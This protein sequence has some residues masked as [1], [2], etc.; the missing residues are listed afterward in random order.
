MI[1][2]EPMSE[3]LLGACYGRWRTISLRSRSRRRRWLAN[4]VLAHF[5]VERIDFGLK[6]RMGPQQD[7][8][9]ACRHRGKYLAHCPKGSAARLMEHRAALGIA[10]GIETAMSAA[11]LFRL[12][13]WAAI[14]SCGLA[15]WVPPAG[16]S[17]VV[18]FGDNDPKFGGQAAA[19]NLAHRLGAKALRCASRYR[20]RSVKIGTM[21]F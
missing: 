19:Y 14:N 5:V 15:A 8:R 20:R 13:C 16:V 21:S 17:E 1:A 10:E 4:I 18:V 2:D 3:R 11:T 7:E 12:P 6:I 9:P